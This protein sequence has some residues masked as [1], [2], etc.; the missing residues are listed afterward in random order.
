VVGC[1][2]ADWLLPL[3][4]PRW[5]CA[6]ILAQNDAREI[7]RAGK[8][9]KIDAGQCDRPTTSTFSRARGTQKPFLLY[10]YTRH[11]MR[12]FELEHELLVVLIAGAG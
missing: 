7:C 5:I 12:L 10:P 11:R 4:S 3:S 9:S 8:A 1:D 6:Y 2:A